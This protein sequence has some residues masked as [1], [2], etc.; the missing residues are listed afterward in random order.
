LINLRP[1]MTT[2]AITYLLISIVIFF[3]TWLHWYYGVPAAILL[4]YASYRFLHSIPKEKTADSSISWSKESLIASILLFLFLL[5]TGHGMFIGGSGYDIPWRNA[6]YYDLIQQSWP[7]LYE[8]SQSALIYYLTYWLAPAGITYVFGSHT[9]L[10][11]IILFLWTYIGLRIFLSLLWN[12]LKAEKKYYIYITLIFLFWS[13]LSTIGMI[14]V[15][16]TGI[17]PFYIDADW[18]WHAW[19]FTAITQNGYTMGYMIRSTFD[20]L[21]NIYNQLIPIVLCTVLFLK[22][23]QPASY[24]LFIALLLPYSPFGAVGLCL[25]AGIDLVRQGLSAFQS[26]QSHSFFKELISPANILAVVAVLPVF[27]LYFTANTSLDQ[28]NSLWS[29][30]LADYTIIRI[31]ILGLYYMFYFIIFADLC[32]SHTKDSVLLGS[33]ILTLMIIPFFKIGRSLDFCWNA[34]IPGFYIIMVFLM[35]EILRLFREHDRSRHFVITM[36]VL[37]IAV[38][39]P[40]LQLTSQCIKCYTAGTYFVYVN[41]PKLEDTLSDKPRDSVIRTYGNFMN[42]YYKDKPFYRYIAK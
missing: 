39:T 14:I 6:M 34:S 9:L 18:G 11:N 4:V 2:A 40:F 8:Y 5:L 33:V 16:A 27:S 23:R 10:A 7:V 20:G 35:Q 41:V 1:Y 3:M 25:L 29:A 32:R 15:S 24:A 28:T 38:T 19:Q 36:V 17:M 31:T 26:H 37:F 30:P 42:P 12:F 21:S 13:G 22:Y